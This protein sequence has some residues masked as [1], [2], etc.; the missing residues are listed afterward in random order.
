MV[1]GSTVE[2]EAPP[3]TLPAVGRLLDDP[4][5]AAPIARWGRPLVADLL[6]EELGALREEILGGGRQEAP[7]D[8]AALAARVDARASRLLAPSP[9]AVINATGI[10]AHTNLGRSILSR[11]AAARVAEAA[12]AY[13]DL[14]YDL[15]TG[16][17]GD[18]GEHLAPLLARL[19]PGHGSIVVNNNAAAIFLALSALAKG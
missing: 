12:T 18:R 19:F 6:R 5:L 2:R 10:V 15:G 9:R 8:P 4:A 1:S 16:R 14:E 11:E 3:R 13:L 17:R 7:G